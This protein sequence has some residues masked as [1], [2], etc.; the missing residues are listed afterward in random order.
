MTG[1][2]N[3]TADEVS[4]VDLPELAMRRLLAWGWDVAKDFL[5]NFVK[6]RPRTRA[7]L[8]RRPLRPRL[9]DLIRLAGALEKLPERYRTVI[10][11]R[12]FD[13][14]AP[15]DIAERLGWPQVRVRVYSKRAVQLL[16]CYLRGK[17]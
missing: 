3:W 5:R 8:A 9:R 12:L 15:Q 16:A 10:E 17:S 6:V 14:L 1:S 7:A 13:R 2:D 11:A 4:L